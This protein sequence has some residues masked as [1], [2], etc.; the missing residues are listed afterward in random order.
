MRTGGP[1]RVILMVRLGV[2]ALTYDVK[3]NGIF[4][5]HFFLVFFMPIAAAMQCLARGAKA[6]SGGVSKLLDK[7]EG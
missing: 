6:F 4:E 1:P 5:F 7:K 2:C 3:E